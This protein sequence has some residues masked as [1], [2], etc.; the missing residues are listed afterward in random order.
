MNIL[1]IQDSFNDTN[2]DKSREVRFPRAA[3]SAIVAE[4]AARMMLAMKVFQPFP[5]NMR[6]DLRR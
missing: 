4:S 5:G 3:G 1:R 2:F 6:I